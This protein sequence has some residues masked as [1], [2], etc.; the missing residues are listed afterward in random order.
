MKKVL[1]TLLA[2]CLIF[3]AVGTALVVSAEGETETPEVTTQT[4]FLTATKTNWKFNTVTVYDNTLFDSVY[5]MK[6]ELSRGGRTVLL[7]SDDI[8]AMADAAAWEEAGV[9]EMRF[10]AKLPY[11]KGTPELNYKVDFSY[12]ATYIKNDGSTAT[13]YPAI[14]A[15]ISIKAD[16]LWHEI[17][18]KASAFGQNTNFKNCFNGTFASPKETTFYALRIEPTT[19]EG[20]IAANG[21][22]YVAPLVEYYDTAITAEVNDGN[23]ALEK[24]AAIDTADGGWSHKNV[25]N[26]RNVSIYDN[27]YYNTS[28]KYTVSDVENYSFS[29]NAYPFKKTGI[30]VE[31]LSDYFKYR[32][33]MQTYVKNTSGHKMTFKVGIKLQYTNSEGAGKQAEGAYKTEEIP[34][35]GKWHE[36]RIAY[37]DLFVNNTSTFYKVLTGATGTLKEIYLKVDGLTGQFTSTTDAI[38]FTPLAIYNTS[39]VGSEI[40]ANVELEQLAKIETASGGWSHTNVKGTSTK[41]TDNK[42]YRTAYKFSVTD[43]ENYNFSGNTYPYLSNS[44]T[45]DDLADYFKYRGDMRTYVK[46]T[47]GHTMTFFIGIKAKYNSNKNA[48]SRFLEEVYVPGDGKWHEVKIPYSSLFVNTSDTFYKVLTDSETYTINELYMKINGLTGQFTSTTDELYFTPLEIYNRNIEEAETTDFAR[49]YNQSM[50]IT[51]YRTDKTDT[52]I[53]KE[54]V[55]LDNESPFFSN[56]VKYTANDSYY[57]GYPSEQIGFVELAGINSELFADWYYNDN[58]DLRI[59]VKAVNGTKFKLGVYITG[60][61]ISSVIEVAA[62]PDWQMVTIPRSAFGE[63][64]QMETVMAGNATV[65]VNI[66]FYAVDGTFA[67][68]GDSISIAQCVEVYSDKA[69]EKGDANCDGVI[70][71]KDLVRIKKQ[72]ADTSANVK[73]CDINNSGSV[74]ALDLTLMRNKLVNGTWN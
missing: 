68:A 38:Y 63:S 50:L 52:Y 13:T 61:I 34:G 20:V 70:G 3:S 72:A 1:A 47:S 19:E 12:N 48:E 21:G 10:W 73:N 17:R 26:T 35:D 46:N 24:V 39:I 44:V 42:F 74:E 16:G 9:G 25:I 15:T 4:P 14:E 53:A 55:A 64:L 36:V 56:A 30:T 11:K 43:A 2:I 65:N 29:G 58:A 33:T 57:A 45:A 41:I 27:K 28:F 32:G 59:W 66:F 23:V 71:I 22:F 67:A 62:S 18:V 6:N 49:E 51:K 5:V 54:S 40:D 31:E 69:Y 37:S 60:E 7:E 8:W